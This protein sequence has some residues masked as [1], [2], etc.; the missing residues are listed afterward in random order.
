MNLSTK[1]AYN[2]IIQIISKLISTVLGLMAIAMI[3]RYLGQ[4]GFG[5]YTTVITFVSYF[6]IFAD[7]GL[8]L[9]TVQL[10]SKPYAD[11]DKIL[12]NL[13]GLRLVSAVFLLSLAP[14]AVIFFPYNPIVKSGVFIASFSFV[15]IALNQILVGLFQKHLRMDKVSIAE[16]AS[17]VVLIIGVYIAL[18]IN[19]GL[20]GIMLATLISSLTNFL[21]QYYYSRSLVRIKLRFDFSYWKEIISSSWPLAITIA[22]NLIYLKTDTLLLSI[23]KRPSAIGIIAEVGIYGAAY[24]VIDVLI[25]FPFMFAGIVLPIMTSLWSQNDKPGFNNVLQKSFDIMVIIA[26]PLLVGTQF[27]AAEL[28]ALVA[29]PEFTASGPILQILIGAAGL[30]FLG[31]MFAHAI[32]AIDKQK[33]I[34]PAYLIT[35]IT[36]VIFYFIFIPRFSYFG[37][38]WT[39]IYSEFSIAFISAILVWKYTKF[40]PNLNVLFKSTIASI[41]MA[42]FIYLFKQTGINSLYSIPFGAIIY[43]IILFLIKGLTKKDINILLNKHEK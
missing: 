15:F 11:Q 40:L 34:I 17:R 22:L 28:M 36:S 24:K 18:K 27:V 26:L 35:A 30:I 1:V 8:T 14:L 25:T 33:K 20:N 16:V 12:G 42:V 31:N 21:I 7:L 29:G 23:L 43:F 19:S 38:A 37:A 5:E 6:A 32:I 2:T 9:V 41:G 39:T 13:L 4:T 10:I 3:T